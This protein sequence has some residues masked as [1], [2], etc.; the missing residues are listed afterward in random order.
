MI[1]PAK[2]IPQEIIQKAEHALK[3]QRSTYQ[4]L[5]DFI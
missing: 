2:G 3:N 4:F 1:Q 5:P